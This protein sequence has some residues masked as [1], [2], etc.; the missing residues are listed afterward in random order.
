MGCSMLIVCSNTASKK[1]QTLMRPSK[2]PVISWKGLLGFRIAVVIMF[3]FAVDLELS[4][5]P[6]RVDTT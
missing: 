1:S 4:G 5:L 2:E 6:V 3:V